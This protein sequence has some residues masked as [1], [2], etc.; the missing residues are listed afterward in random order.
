MEMK[1]TFQKELAEV[2][3]IKRELKKE[4]NLIDEILL[5]KSR[6]QVIEKAVPTIETNEPD[7]LR[8][9]ILEEKKILRKGGDAE[10]KESVITETPAYA[11][12]EYSENQPAQI[13][14]QDQ[15]LQER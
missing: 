4:A 5:E 13:K 12:T 15:P 8:E 3:K 1:E 2:T 14:K 6:V 11:D 7:F 9:E 10:K